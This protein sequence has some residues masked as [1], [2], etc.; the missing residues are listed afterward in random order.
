MGYDIR[1]NSITGKWEV[2]EGCELY[3]DTDNYEDAHRVFFNCVM[4][5]PQFEDEPEIDYDIE[6]GYEPFDNVEV[7]GDC[8]D[9]ENSDLLFIS[10]TL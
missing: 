5:E 8:Y 10:Q 2:W 3:Y 6:D 7:E 4:L 1:Y 9:T